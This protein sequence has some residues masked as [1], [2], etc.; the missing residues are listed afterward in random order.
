MVTL[1]TVKY[2]GQLSKR[3]PLNS[4]LEEEKKKTETGNIYEAFGIKNNP[5]QQTVAQALWSPQALQG[6]AAL[7]ATWLQSPLWV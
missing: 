7:S 4:N 1:S 6:I 2:T 5:R 3:W